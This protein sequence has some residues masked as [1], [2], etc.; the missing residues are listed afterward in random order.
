MPIK[1]DYGFT[2]LDLLFWIVIQFVMAIVRTCTA[3]TM[4]LVSW[5]LNDVCV[6]CMLRDNCLGVQHLYSSRQ[7]TLLGVSGRFLHRE[8]TSTYKPIPKHRRYADRS[9][10]FPQTPQVLQVNN[11]RE[12][13][14]T[15]NI[16]PFTDGDDRLIYSPLVYRKSLPRYYFIG[17]EGI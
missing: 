16:E 6:E 14:L 5:C 3:C 12:T 10:V 2:I 15:V 8:I 9:M 13:G 1:K 17:S 11:L 7:Q 4:V